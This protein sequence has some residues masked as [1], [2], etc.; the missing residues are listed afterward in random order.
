MNNKKILLNL[1]PAVEEILHILFWHDARLLLP[2]QPVPPHLPGAVLALPA[3]VHGEHLA[4]VTQQEAR[5]R[6]GYVEQRVSFAVKLIATD[7][8]QPFLPLR[9]NLRQQTVRVCC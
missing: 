6:S 1:R 5:V 2:R 3:G 9:S 8:L 7:Q 4:V